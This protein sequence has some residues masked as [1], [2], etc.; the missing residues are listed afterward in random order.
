MKSPIADDDRLGLL[1]GDEMAGVGDGDEA[2]VV[3]QVV[4]AVELDR[5]QGLVPR[6]PR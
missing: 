2:E 5:E 4:Q 3:D 1:P 6:A